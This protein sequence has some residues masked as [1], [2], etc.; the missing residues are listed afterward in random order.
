[1]SSVPF[2]TNPSSWIINPYALCQK[3]NFHLLSDNFNLKNECL[4]SKMVSSPR[5]FGETSIRKEQQEISSMSVW[6]SGSLWWNLRNMLNFWI[7]I[8]IQKSNKKEIFSFITTSVESI[9]IAYYDKCYFQQMS[10]VQS[11]SKW[12]SEQLWFCCNFLLE[13]ERLTWLVRLN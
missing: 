5:S 2:M 8:W 3:V 9:I 4:H 10:F 12:M 11:I 13:D 1:M 7:I 6:G